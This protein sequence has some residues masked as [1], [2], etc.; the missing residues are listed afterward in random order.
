MTGF[1]TPAKDI[2]LL[3]GLC[4]WYNTFDHFQKTD[5]TFDPFEENGLTSP[6]DYLRL[7]AELKADKA[8]ENK[9]DDGDLNRSVLSQ[10]SKLSESILTGSQ[11]K[12][13]EK[14][15]IKM[16]PSIYPKIP[17]KNWTITK[18]AFTSIASAHGLDAALNGLPDD[19]SA[20]AIVNHK[21]NCKLMYSA[22]MLA[23]NSGDDA[24]IVK[25]HDRN[26][27]ES[28][29]KAI[30]E[31][32]EGSG[33]VNTRYQQAMNTLQ[34]IRFNGNS[35]ESFSRHC[36]QF[37]EA[38]QILQEIGRPQDPEAVRLFF[39]NS[40]TADCCEMAKQICVSLDYDL[41][42]II[43]EIRRAIQVLEN[44]VGSNVRHSNTEGVKET[45]MSKDE[46]EAQIRDLWKYVDTRIPPEIWGKLNQQVRKAYGSKRKKYHEGRR[47]KQNEESRASENTSNGTRNVRFSNGDGA[48]AEGP[49]S[50]LRG[51]NTQNEEP[52]SGGNA[53][54]PVL[55]SNSTRIR[56]LVS[57][58]HIM[59]SSILSERRINRRTTEPGTK[60][61]VDGGADTCLFNPEDV[62]VESTTNRVVDLKTVGTDGRR[63][64][65]PIGTCIVTVDIGGK[66]IL[67]VFNES[68]IGKEGD[69]N[70]ISAN[71][72]RRYGHC[73]DDLARPFGG[74]QCIRL[75]SSQTEIP[76]ELR[77]ALIYLPFKKPTEEQL[78]ECE[79]IYLTSDGQWDPDA[80]HD[81][82][83][84]NQTIL[85]G[86]ERIDLSRDDTEEEQDDEG[87]GCV[88]ARTRSRTT[89]NANKNVKTEERVS[90]VEEVC[91][92][93]NESAL[94]FGAEVDR[95][96]LN[97]LELEPYVED[98]LEIL[99]Q[100]SIALNSTDNASLSPELVEETRA[101][102][103]WVSQNV[104]EHTLKATTQLSKNFLRLPLRRHF[105]S[106]E[107]ILNRNRLAEEY[108]TDTF[109]SETKSI[110]DN[111][112]AAQIFV[113]RKSY[114]TKVYGMVAEREAPTALNDFIREIGAPR[115]IHSDNA[116]VETSKKWK[117]ILRQYQ[118][119]E[120]YMEPHH[121]QQ[122]P[123][124]RRIGT[125]KELTRRIL[126]RSGAPAYL[127]YCAMLYAGGLL[128]ITA[129]QNLSWRMPTE[130]AFRETPDISG[131]LQFTFYQRV[132][133]LDPSASFPRNKELPGRFVGVAE[134]TGDALT[135]YV[136]TDHTNQIIARSVVR[137]ASEDPMIANQ[138]AN[139]EIDPQE[140]PGIAQCPNEPP[141]IDSLNEALGQRAPVHSTARPYGIYVCRHVGRHD[142]EGYGY[143]KSGRRSR[144]VA[145]PI[146]TWRG[147]GKTLPRGHR[148]DKPY[149]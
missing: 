17:G 20:T 95:S 116:K 38:N 145:G 132:L 33:N 46:V 10:I 53:D 87:T 92:I 8:R 66:P 23:T 7:I 40:I 111:K 1:L 88:G 37:M 105:K 142:T 94:Y 65:V 129:Q 106:R 45:G 50:I 100:R 42:K 71:Q 139:H 110:E 19:A 18:A 140:E 80:L 147:R 14:P 138:R 41:N 36:N 4:S 61:C 59:R 67:L 123:A 70:I 82:M 114:F 81:G 35:P 131:Y 62:F 69:T 63:N 11:V 83:R 12:P 97:L 90:F 104:A 136:L 108:C 13:E 124:E 32:H 125:I 43:L 72:V 127:W 6:R 118:I 51:R 73:V 134:N 74:G 60:A 16:D 27:S 26:D 15:R 112:M 133:Y 39:L 25:S 64:N 30:C 54:N 49:T 58:N 144:S 9:A 115:G 96:E 68:L 28:V 55:P 148:A 91:D 98:T 117:D 2:D 48:P 122:N 44:T 47:N 102:L 86:L 130:A 128:N 79:R 137:P 77:R 22:L 99:D 101:R 89:A 146:P 103:G 76:L 126:D 56:N 109:F 21:S 57:N 5:E 29:W 75:A 84:S 93:P 34:G 119:G 113:G 78:N 149:E 3:G 135:Y 24:W 121:P 85:D 107:P 52:L 141:T 143:R 120:S 31:W